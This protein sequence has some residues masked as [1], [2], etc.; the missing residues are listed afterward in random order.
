MNKI[1]PVATATF[2]VLILAAC[3]SSSNTQQSSNLATA[4]SA[5]S[6][7]STPIDPT[8]VATISGTVKFD[9]VAPAPKKIDMSQDPGCSGSNEGESLVVSDGHLAN[10]FV[11]IKDGLGNRTFKPPMTPVII[12]QRGCRYHPHVLGAMTGQII[13]IRNDDPTTHNIH[14]M[15]KHNR[16]WNVSETASSPLIQQSFANEEIMMPMKCNLHPWMRMYINIVK[17]PFFAVTDQ[18]GKYEIQGLPPGEYT[19]AFV[20]E[21][22]GEQDVKV[23]LGPKES[24]TVDATFK[25]ATGE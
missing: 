10:V 19:I 2:L 12:D 9:G 8:T 6:A 13:Q 4:N 22:L 1:L 24:R 14:P 21:K 20:Q 7:D 3:S 16:E 11:Y 15:P 23:T 5:V 17:N 18:S 25:S